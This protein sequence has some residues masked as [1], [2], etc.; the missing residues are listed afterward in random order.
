M[1]YKQIDIRIIKFD[2][3]TISVA[4]LWLLIFSENNYFSG[5]V[6]FP[7]GEFTI[8]IE[9]G[10]LQNCKKSKSISKNWIKRI[11]FDLALV[12]AD[13]YKKKSTS[14]GKKWSIIRINTEFH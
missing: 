4:Y 8:I 2:F 1:I 13:R 12:F 9:E 11:F 5:N 6:F 10:K 14:L 3:S 7:P